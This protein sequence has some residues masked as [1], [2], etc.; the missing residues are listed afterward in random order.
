MLDDVEIT[1]DECPALE[2]FIEIEGKSANA[3]K[4]VIKKIGFDYNMAVF[5][6]VGDVYKIRYGISLDKIEDEVGDIVFNNKK[7]STFVKDLD[8]PQK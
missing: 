4:D 1:I 6:A 2:P 3:V 8:Y 5:G 7:L